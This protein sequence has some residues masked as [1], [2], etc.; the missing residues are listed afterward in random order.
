VTVINASISQVTII[1]ANTS[2]KG[3]VL[4]NQSPAKLYVSSVNGFSKAAA[5]VV[6]QAMSPW[7]L[8]V[9]YT[10]VLYGVWDAATGRAQVTEV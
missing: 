10:G 8:Q 2:R 1:A 4:F 6:I 5:P 9:A 7:P 3:L